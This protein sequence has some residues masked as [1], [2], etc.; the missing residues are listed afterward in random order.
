[1]TKKEK[2]YK[3]KVTS[4][5]EYELHIRTTA[6]EDEVISRWR[7]FD[8]GLFNCTYNEGWDFDSLEEIEDPE[9]VDENNC[10]DMEEKTNG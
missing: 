5:E 4:T 10:I 7:S 6:D 3:L 8:G 2:V 1:M 9:D